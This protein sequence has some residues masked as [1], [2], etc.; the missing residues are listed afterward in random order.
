V[1]GNG[2]HTCYESLLIVT[3]C[4]LGRCEVDP[5]CDLIGDALNMLP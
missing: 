3:I 4:A 5:I 1:V 2:Q